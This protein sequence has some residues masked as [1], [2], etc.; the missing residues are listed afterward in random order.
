MTSNN[1]SL[2]AIVPAAGVGS[3]MGADIPK[4]YL[5]LNE[6]TI[7]EHTLDRLLTVEGV[8]SVIVA[9]SEQDQW[10]DTLPMA[11]DPRVLRVSGGKERADSV[12][13]GLKRAIEIKADMALVH[14]AA[15]P[16]VLNQDIAALIEHVGNAADGGLLAV[17]VRDTMKRSA[18]DGTVAHTVDRERL[19][20]A[21]TPQ[22]FPC[23][24]LYDAIAAALAAEIQVTDEA[25][26]MEWAGYH[27]KLVA[28][29]DSNIKVT[30]P[31]DLKLAA[32]F[33]QEETL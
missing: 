28:G 7:L 24:T 30:R 9:I 19:W 20:H 32:F 15:R 14:D 2:V 16:C 6:R 11:K 25:S 22:L 17:P 33:L 13:N 1:A 4:Q 21:L 12:L 8:E 31:G 18:P 10:F 5:K 26:A 27:P 29:C 3:R 23:Q